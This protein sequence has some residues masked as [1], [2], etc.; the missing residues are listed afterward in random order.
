[1]GLSF[2]LA[3]CSSSESVEASVERLQPACVDE[4][5]AL[6]LADW[7]CPEP[8][9]VEC[10]DGAAS[11]ETIFVHPDEDL[12]DQL[13]EDIALSINDEGPFPLG[14]HEIVVT[15]EAE[16][17]RGDPLVEQCTAALEVV[18]TQ[19]PELGEER[20]IE[21]W[22]P[23]H[24]MHSVSVEAC[25][26]VDDACD[27]DLEL[28]FL[29]AGSDE[30]VNDVGDGNTEPDVILGCDEAQLRAERQGPG[31]GRVYTLYWRAVDDEGLSVEGT[32]RV[33]VPHDQSGRPA[34]G[35]DPSEPSVAAPD[36]EE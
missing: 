21:L 5:E 33:A 29:A 7:L 13:C 9:T 3:A 17:E 25:A 19:P 16:D 1:M 15:A 30:P 14:A 11:V 8:F 26:N 12:A 31:D 4:L 32:C 2:A 6:E 10:V 28:Y 20:V 36:C 23:N 35:S 18:D 34:V 24:K 27:R 22:P